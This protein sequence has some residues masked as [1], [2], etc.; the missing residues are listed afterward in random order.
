MILLLNAVTHR[1]SPSPRD[2]HPPRPTRSRQNLACISARGETLHPGSPG[3]GQQRRADN[4]DGHAAGELARLLARRGDLD[5]LRARADVGDWSAA[6]RLTEL[7][8]E[9]GDL[10]GA[11]QLLRAQADAL[12]TGTPC[13]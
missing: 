7:L 10:D 3:L 13:G 5:G 9:R 1:D 4:G 6:R 8:R 12:A 11:E 2:D